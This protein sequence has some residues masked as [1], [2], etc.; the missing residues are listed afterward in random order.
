MLVSHTTFIVCPNCKLPL[1]MDNFFIVI[2]EQFHRL[3]YNV[4]KQ[5]FPEV[6]KIEFKNRSE[7]NA[8][9]KVKNVISGIIRAEFKTPGSFYIH[10]VFK[11]LPY[12]PEDLKTHLEKN[13][14]SWM[15]WS[16]WGRYIVKTWDDND[17]STWKW[18]ID[19]LVPRSKFHYN[20]VTDDSFQACWSLDNLRPLNAK[21]NLFD[22]V[23]RVRH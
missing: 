2:N 3:K 7:I 23:K 8:T 17:P 10:D 1:S 14:K 19:H 4:C 21:E 13:F 9:N 12:S 20:S 15:N 11:F 18:Q 22:G 5:C 16:N 6:L